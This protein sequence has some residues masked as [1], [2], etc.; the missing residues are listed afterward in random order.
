MLALYAMLV[1]AH[2]EVNAQEV[3]SPETGFQ[4]DF[5]FDDNKASRNPGWTRIRFNELD[6]NGEFIFN[7]IARYHYRNSPLGYE[8]R[9]GFGMP[10][11][12]GAYSGRATIFGAKHADYEGAGFNF[13]GSADGW[14]IGGMLEGTDSAN[15]NEQLYGIQLGRCFDTKTGKAKLITGLHNL[16]GV[17]TGTLLWY[18]E[19]QNRMDSAAGFKWNE[20]GDRVLGLSLGQC[21]P[22]F[23]GVNWRLFGKTDFKGCYSGML[24]VAWDTHP[25]YRYAVW[26]AMNPVDGFADV[27]LV[28]NIMNFPQIYRHERGRKLVFEAEFKRR[29]DA[30]DSVMLGTAVYPLRLLGNE[31]SRIRPHLDF[32]W[33]SS[34]ES[35]GRK[36]SRFGAGILFN[37]LE[38]GRES[39][40]NFLDAGV[41]ADSED[42][43]MCYLQLVH[44]F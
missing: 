25:N 33:N 22:A 30:D 17:D 2:A 16:R 10:F 24:H 43:T 7:D 14:I 38:G 28:P 20:E 4:V 32:D 21:S 39:T 1:M 8:E 36:Y 42:V 12:I 19:G 40:T 41:S 29:P 23:G 11:G 18:H 5:N 9:L 35:T 6:E 34:S 44:N 13:F 27:S 31:Q 26:G 15:E 37:L 3:R